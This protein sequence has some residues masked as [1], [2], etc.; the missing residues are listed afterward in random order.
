MARTSTTKLELRAAAMDA[1]TL[2]KIRR[3]WARMYRHNLKMRK[4]RSR[5][6]K[7]MM[8]LSVMA[9]VM[10]VYDAWSVHQLLEYVFLGKT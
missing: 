2:K 4:P 5:Y 8:T 6:F 3:K 7:I 9:A 10:L 1:F